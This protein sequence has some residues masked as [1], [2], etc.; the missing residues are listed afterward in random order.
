MAMRI[1][2]TGVSIFGTKAVKRESRPTY[3]AWI[4]TLP[5]VLTGQ[6]GVDA[7]HLSAANDIVGHFGRG[8]AQKADDTWVLPLV[9]AL[10]DEQGSMNELEF[11][12]R[13][14]FNP[15]LA[16]LVLFRIFTIYPTDVATEVA[17]KIISKGIGR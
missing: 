13:H 1:A 4:R 17:T 5:C 14:G 6:Y 9:R 10:H 7:A 11:W 12:R 16:C 2:S 8:K 15:Y 3:L